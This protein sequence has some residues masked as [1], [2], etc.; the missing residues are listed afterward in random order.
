MSVSEAQAR[1]SS[2]EYAMWQARELI[3]PTGELR[4]DARAATI[5][6][7]IFNAQGGKTKPGDFLPLFTPDDQ[8]APCDAAEA[9]ADKVRAGFAGLA[10]RMN[11]P[12]GKRRPA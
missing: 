6:S 8:A 11:Q 3:E 12:G 9:V 4:A 2:R 10:E 1:I 5:I 7:A